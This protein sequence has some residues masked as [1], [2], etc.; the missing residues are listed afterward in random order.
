MSPKRPASTS[1]SSSRRRGSRFVTRRHPSARGNALK[2]STASMPH[3]P[4]RDGRK[5]LSGCRRVQNAMCEIRLPPLVVVAAE[6]TRSLGLTESASRTACERPK[7]GDGLVVL[8][9]I[10]HKLLGPIQHVLGFSFVLTICRLSASCTLVIRL[11]IHST[12]ARDGRFRRARR[13]TLTARRS[14]TQDSVIP[15]GA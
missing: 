6:A 1:I 3:R 5:R 4:R 9:A 10:A 12:T 8:A 7:R 13:C 11:S 2:A 15:T 14:A